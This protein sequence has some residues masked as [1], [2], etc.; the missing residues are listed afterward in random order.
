MTSR[1]GGAN[2]QKYLEGCNF[3]APS[4]KNSSLKYDFR[5]VFFSPFHFS[6]M[7]KRQGGGDLSWNGTCPSADVERA[8]MF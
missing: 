2:T 7:V 1:P 3:A 4:A 5:V 6:L 8:N